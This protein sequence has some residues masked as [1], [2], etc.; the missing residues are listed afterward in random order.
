MLN[1]G[2]SKKRKRPLWP[3]SGFWSTSDT[4]AFSLMKYLTTPGT[5]SFS[6]CIELIDEHFVNAPSLPSLSPGRRK[7]RVRSFTFKSADGSE[8]GWSFEFEFAASAS[9]GVAGGVL[10]AEFAA[11][12][13][14]AFFAGTRREQTKEFLLFRNVCGRLDQVLWHTASS[15]WRTH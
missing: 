14:A 1:T 5:G 10:A 7:L 9:V 6:L 12:A 2:D 4:G 11:A 8:S 13:A 15:I 3:F